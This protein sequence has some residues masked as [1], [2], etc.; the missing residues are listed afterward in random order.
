MHAGMS[1]LA[2]DGGV[3]KIPLDAVL[4][5]RRRGAARWRASSDRGQSSS[6][7]AEG[8]K[9]C[10]CCRDVDLDRQCRHFRA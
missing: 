5:E 2:C 7:L 3:L 8:D 1:D 10:G 4:A 6:D 9:I